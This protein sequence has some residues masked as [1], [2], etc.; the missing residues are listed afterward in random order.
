MSYLIAGDEY[1]AIDSEVWRSGTFTVTEE[2]LTLL[3]RAYVR[4]D[5]CEF[6]APAIDPKRPYG[7]S[8][9]ERDIAEIL[10]EPEWQSAVAEDERHDDEAARDYYLSRN[11]DR[12]VRLHAETGV[13]LQIVLATGQFAAGYYRR[14]KL[15]SS[16]WE[17]V[18]TSAWPPA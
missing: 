11:R 2:H 12:L 3:R 1:R 5:D 17:R 15:G 6:G 18:D 9:V 14:A 7:N 10:N 8:G 4:W 13:A 16:S